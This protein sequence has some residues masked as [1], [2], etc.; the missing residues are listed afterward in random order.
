MCQAKELAA[1]HNRKRLPEAAATGDESNKLVDRP[2][3]EAAASNSSKRTL[4]RRDSNETVAKI[5][6]DNF[7]GFSEYQCDMLLV[8]GRSLREKLKEDKVLQQMGLLTMGKTYYDIAR[9]M[10]ADDSNPTKRL[11]FTN[12]EE[13]PDDKLIAALQGLKSHS[14]DKGKLYGWM[15]SDHIK[16]QRS[17]V[18]FLRA[19]LIGGERCEHNR[20]FS[21]GRR[22][23]V[24]RD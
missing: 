1:G 6:R 14:G 3:D 16:N 22:G 21:F 17:L 24:C 18:I 19:T 10:Y 2:S 7:R 9:R 8:D 12:P 11:K 13:V 4:R 5:L 20:I 23:V 15:E